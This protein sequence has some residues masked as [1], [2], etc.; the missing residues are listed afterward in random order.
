MGQAGNALKGVTIRITSTGT[1]LKEVFG[2]N[3]LGQQTNLGYYGWFWWRYGDYGGPV[4]LI[5][6]RNNRFFPEDYSLATGYGYQ[7]QPGV[8]CD[9]DK[10][11]SAGIHGSLQLELGDAIDVMKG[12]VKGLRQVGFAGHIGTPPKLTKM[13]RDK[14]GMFHLGAQENV[15]L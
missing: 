15:G 12:D 5:N 14:K 13:F 4:H 2:N 1:K 6:H 11:W 10:I 3:T 8:T 7:M 9:I